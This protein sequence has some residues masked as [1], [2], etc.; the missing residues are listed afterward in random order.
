MT[1]A[2]GARAFLDISQTLPQ[3]LP[4]VPVLSR[5]YAISSQHRVGA[6]D[7]VYVALAER[8]CCPFITAD[9]RLVKNLQPQFPFILALSSLP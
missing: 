5:A 9:D 7:C 6:Y 8:E 3:L 4:S 1:P 2:E